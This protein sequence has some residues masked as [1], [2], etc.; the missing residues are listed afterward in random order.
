MLEYILEFVDSIVTFNR[1][2]E[3]AWINQ[4]LNVY[5]VSGRKRVLGIELKGQ[6]MGAG[7]TG[8]SIS[9]V[10]SGALLGYLRVK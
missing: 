2:W 8:F 1:G 4:G 7:D 6:K 3:A 5:S 10:R 9:M